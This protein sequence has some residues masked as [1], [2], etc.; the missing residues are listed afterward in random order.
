MTCPEDC[1]RSLSPTPKP[2][3]GF[4]SPAK[5]ATMP[6]IFSASLSFYGEMIPSMFPAPDAVRSSEMAAPGG[7]KTT[8]TRP[9]DERGIAD[10]HRLI[11]VSCVLQQRA[12]FQIDC[13]SGQSHG[14]LFATDAMSSDNSAELPHAQ[15]C[16]I[17]SNAASEAKHDNLRCL[18]RAWMNLSAAALD[19]SQKADSAS[20]RA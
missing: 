20:R 14:G 9:V 12:I 7:R 15:L 16:R 3:G 18:W 13:H 11:F 5:P 8:A 4:C 6:M 1:G 2:C 17:L 10:L 19:S